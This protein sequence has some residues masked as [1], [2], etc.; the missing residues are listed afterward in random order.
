MNSKFQIITGLREHIYSKQIDNVFVEKYEIRK[1]FTWD[2][3]KT[4][5]QI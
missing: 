4:I 3:A 2:Y 5:F 1:L